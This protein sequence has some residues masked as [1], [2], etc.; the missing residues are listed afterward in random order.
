MSVYIGIDWSE[1]QH[2]I[3]FMNE[4]G[5]RIAH[6][7]AGL[8]RLEKTREQLGVA[9]SACWVTTATGLD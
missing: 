4:A 8:E 1:T 2:E 6:T 5:A 7:G 9:A 3:V